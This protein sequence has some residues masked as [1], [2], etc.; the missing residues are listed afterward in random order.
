VEIATARSFILNRGI[1]IDNAPVEYKRHYNCNLVIVTKI[2]LYSA[3][4]YPGN[5]M[6]FVEIENCCTCD[7]PNMQ[8]FPY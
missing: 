5:F 8:I 2:V 6:Q 1:V 7:L 3:T 4:Q